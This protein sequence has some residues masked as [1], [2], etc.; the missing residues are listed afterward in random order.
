VSVVVDPA[1]ESYAGASASEYTTDA[2][3]TVGLS[4]PEEDVT[5]NVTAEYEN[6][7]T[8]TTIDP[9]PPTGSLST[10]R[11]PTANPS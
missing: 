11:A 10:S 9:R 3:G 1:N 8:T 2:N 4:T 7:S 6:D 5:V